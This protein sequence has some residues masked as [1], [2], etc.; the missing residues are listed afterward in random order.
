MKGTGVALVTPFNEDFSIDF[1]ALGKIIEHGITGKLDYLVVL[2]TTG[3]GPTL[4]KQEKKDVFAYVAHKVAGRIPLVA[5]IGGN[6]TSDVIDDMLSFNPKGYEA[7]LSVAP[8]YNKPNQE[9]IYQHFMALAKV[10]PLPIIIYN[11]PGR[12]GVGISAATTLRLAN[13][14]DKFIATK[15]AS[16]NPE[17]FM[18]ILKDK[19]DRFAVVSGDDNLTVPFIALGMTGVIS[20][21]AQAYP[22]LYSD[23]VRHALK[24]NFNEASAIHFKLYNIM[25]AIFADG[26]PGGIKVVLSQMGLCKNIVRLPLVTV[27]AQVNEQLIRLTQELV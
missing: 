17:V 2:G 27:N 8:Y 13:A 18:D 24:G 26:N 14:S 3:E 10:S 5:G 6:N 4:S 15:E 19:P 22:R 11:V 7:I 20:V 25:K 21:I 16:G 1:D 12:T 23:M 9:G